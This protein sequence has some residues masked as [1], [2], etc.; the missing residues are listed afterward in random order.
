MLE[1]KTPY[2]NQSK[3]KTRLKHSDVAQMPPIRRQPRP[4][5]LL[6]STDEPHNELAVAP[7][8]TAA[9][10]SSTATVI[11]LLDS[12]ATR[13]CRPGLG[14]FRPLLRRKVLPPHTSTRPDSFILRNRPGAFLRQDQRFRMRRSIW[15]VGR[16]KSD[17]NGKVQLWS[18]PLRAHIPQEVPDSCVD[19]GRG[20]ARDLPEFSSNSGPAVLGRDFG[21][22]SAAGVRRSGIRSVGN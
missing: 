9:K 22:C 14:G 5:I 6:V 11:R 12:G 8:H 3:C 21:C 18:A 7:L 19:S 16:P 10:S 2:S 4:L 13:R 15:R 17:A 20:N 1:V